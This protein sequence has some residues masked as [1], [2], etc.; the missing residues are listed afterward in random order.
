MFGSLPTR[1]VDL[2]SLCVS[3]NFHRCRANNKCGAALFLDV[4]SGF[5]RSLRAALMRDDLSVLELA[6]IFEKLNLDPS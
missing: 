5:D 6:S 4:L 2:A 1:G 3:S